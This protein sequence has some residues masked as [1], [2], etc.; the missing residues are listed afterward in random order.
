[1]HFLVVASCASGSR[2]SQGLGIYNQSHAVHE[3]LLASR[4]Y[5]L[6]RI[7]FIWVGARS[8]RRDGWSIQILTVPV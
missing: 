6:H 1:M 4:R 5:C 7:R 3:K 8:A 2:T